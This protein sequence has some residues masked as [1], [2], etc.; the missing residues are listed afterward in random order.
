M[1]PRSRTARSSSR[2]A[3]SGFGC[4]EGGEAL[5]AVGPPRT[6]LRHAIVDASEPIRRPGRVP[7]CAAPAWSGTGPERPPPCSSMSARRPSPRSASRAPFSPPS[8]MAETESSG[9]GADAHAARSSAGRMCSSMAIRR[10]GALRSAIRRFA[11]QARS[12]HRLHVVRFHAFDVDHHVVALDAQR[13]FGETATLA[14]EALAGAAVEDP[15]VVRTHQR[16]AVEARVGQGFAGMRAKNPGRRAACRPSARARETSV[17][18]TAATSRPPSTRS[19]QAA[20]LQE[21]APVP[22]SA[23]PPCPPAGRSWAPG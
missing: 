18:S 19:S 5:E 23:T 2:G 9:G 21:H 7:D 22:L 3:A 12:R 20:C 1:R 8:A 17:R 14:L 16:V 11:A 4:G 6:G 15:V 10:N 13:V